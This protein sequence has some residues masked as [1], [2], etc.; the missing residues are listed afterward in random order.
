MPLAWLAGV[1]AKSGS[2]V[3]LRVHC[4]NTRNDVWPGP[5]P[6]TQIAYF[7]VNPLP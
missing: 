2:K 5:N 7:L 4:N 6:G 3:R 1:T